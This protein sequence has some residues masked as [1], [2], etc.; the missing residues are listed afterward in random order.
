MKDKKKINLATYA[1]Y[2]LIQVDISSLTICKPILYL[3]G[4]ME[5]F[6]IFQTTLKWKNKCRQS[7]LLYTKWMSWTKGVEMP[8]L[9]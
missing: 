6:S 3:D 1:D 2:Q 9:L 8:R 4:R 7:L 5:M